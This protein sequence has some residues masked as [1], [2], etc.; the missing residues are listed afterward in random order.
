MKIL[1]ERDEIITFIT[2]SIKVLWL[3]YELPSSSSYDDTIP[4]TMKFITISSSNQSL[5]H[6]CNDNSNIKDHRSNSM[7][8]TSVI[9]MLQSENDDDSVP[10]LKLIDENW[11]NY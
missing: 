4:D 2:E 7:Y 6:I 10:G 1:P 8:D 5:S 3:I 9:D 11:I